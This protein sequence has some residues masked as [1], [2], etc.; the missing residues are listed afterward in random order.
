MW[1]FLLTFRYA[2]V[3]PVKRTINAYIK[4]SE[5]PLW[6]RFES[7]AARLRLTKSGALAQAAREWCDKHQS[8][9][10]PVP[11]GQHRSYRPGVEDPFKT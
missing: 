1:R 8:D 4:P 5:Y 2:H 3:M 9:P 10:T 6:D 11:P 7:L